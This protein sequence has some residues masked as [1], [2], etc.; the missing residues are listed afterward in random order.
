VKATLFEKPLDLKFLQISLRLGGLVT[1]AI[2][3]AHL[4]FPGSGY[5]HNIPDSMP[6]AVRAHFYY[7]ATYAIATFLLSIGSISVL[8]SRL[9]HVPSAVLIACVLAVLWTARFGLE[10]LYPVEVRLFVMAR[11]SVILLPLIGVLAAFYLASAALNL[12]RLA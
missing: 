4:L 8:F 7:L 2:G 1:V 9:N 11:P 3:L 12:H 6:P 5:S 10:I